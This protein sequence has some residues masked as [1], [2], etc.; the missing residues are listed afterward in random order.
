MGKTLEDIV[1]SDYFLN[2]TPVVQEIRPRIDKWD[3]IKL[4]NFCTSKETVTRM[5]TTHKMETI[6]ASYSTDKELISRICNAFKKTKE[7]IIQLVSGQVA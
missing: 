5:K 3:Y 1:I 2:R 4:K 6:F 7:Q